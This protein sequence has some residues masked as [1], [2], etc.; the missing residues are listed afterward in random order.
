MNENQP[1]GWNR[2]EIMWIIGIAAAIIIIGL[3]LWGNRAGVSPAT[4]VTPAAIAWPTVP[5]TFTPTP[6]PGATEAPAT[7]TPTSTP[8]A[9]PTATSTATPSPTPTPTPI[10]VGWRELGYLTTVQYTLQT[11]V[12][13]ERENVIL[14]LVSSTDSVLLLTVGNVQ[15]GIDMTQ[16]SSDDV[17]IDGTSVHLTLPRA[18]ITSVELLPGETKIYDSNRGWFQSDYAGIEVEALSEARRRLEGWAIDRVDIYDQAET[19]ARL[20]LTDFLRQLGF[21]EIDIT[22]EGDNGP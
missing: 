12:E 11:V 8:T 3:V 5:P 22:F 19:L 20:Q 4:T 6:V 1:T 7:L 18:E 21:D 13:V 17:T 14:G 10:V 2:N 16:V 9:P 15:A